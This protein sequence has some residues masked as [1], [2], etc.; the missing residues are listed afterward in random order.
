VLDDKNGQIEMKDQNG[1]SIVMSS[2]GIAIKSNKTISIQAAQNVSIKGDT[3]IAV[4]S[5]A[6]DVTTK[7]INIQETAQMQYGAKGSV[8]AQVEGGVSL[9]LK[10]AMV[11]IN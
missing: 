7:G 6:G 3:G 4:E 9:T 1:N 8:S 10:A 5:S 11:M 2:S